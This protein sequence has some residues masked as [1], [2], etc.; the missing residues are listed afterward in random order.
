MT[1]RQPRS[2]LNDTKLTL[3]ISTAIFSTLYHLTGCI[4][5]NV[6]H[7]DVFIYMNCALLW[8]HIFFMHSSVDGHL[9]WFYIVP[10]TLDLHSPSADFTAVHHQAGLL[11]MQFRLSYSRILVATH[12]LSTRHK[13]F[14]RASLVELAL[15]KFSVEWRGFCSEL[16]GRFLM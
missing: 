14:Q 5:H 8:S 3:T 1:T 6:F 12:W 13:Q 4:G 9:G 16:L 15:W 7:C 2:L 11:M 10:W